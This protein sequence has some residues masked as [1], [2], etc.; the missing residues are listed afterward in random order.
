MPRFF[1]NAVYGGYWYD[2]L[3]T[4][5]FSGICYDGCINYLLSDLITNIAID[6]ARRRFEKLYIAI[7]STLSGKGFDISIVK[8][9]TAE[10]IYYTILVVKPGRYDVA[11]HVMPSPIKESSKN[12]GEN[13][14]SL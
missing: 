1:F 14:H 4:L 5:R 13:G 12:S 8:E 7:K 3:K 2:Y 11:I 9:P 10:D 6:L